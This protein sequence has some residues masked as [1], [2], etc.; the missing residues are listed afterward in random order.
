MKKILKFCS[1][2]LLAVL[3]FSFWYN[4][5]NAKEVGACKPCKVGGDTCLTGFSCTDGQCKDPNRI[6]FCPISSKEEP[7][8]LV[9]EVSKWMM[10]V[11]LVL[12]PLMI[13]L[14]AFYILTA[15]GDTK[16]STKGKQIIIWASI[17]LAIFLFAK[18]F[19]SI[20]KSFLW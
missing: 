5:V 10:I 2:I 4:S 18:A 16:R 11:A 15:A 9:N 1:V 6:T 17:G 7:K 12:A 14:G 13:L 20:L 8:D 3:V 19:I